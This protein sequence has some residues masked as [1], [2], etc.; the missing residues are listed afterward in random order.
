MGKTDPCDTTGYIK[1]S[2]HCCVG[3]L[4]TAVDIISVNQPLKF[5]GSYRQCSHYVKRLPMTNGPSP[6]SS[7]S[8]AA[9]T[10]P[11]QLLRE[12]EIISGR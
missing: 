9:P 12:M 3:K 11:Q 5:I 8:S 1:N 6:S 2:V 4:C 7:S 10:T